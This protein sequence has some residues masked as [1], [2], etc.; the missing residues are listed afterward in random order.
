M[1]T[2]IERNFITS[3]TRP[4][5]PRRC[6]QKRTGP[7]EFN[8]ITAARIVIRGAKAR[9]S[10][11]ASMISSTRLSMALLPDNG[12]LRTTSEF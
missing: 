4:L 6:C 11:D 9:S 2:Y 10:A 7:G 12:A 3:N 1:L 5:K 8:L